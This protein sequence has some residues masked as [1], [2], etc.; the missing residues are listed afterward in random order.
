MPASASERIESRFKLYES[1]KSQNADHRQ[2]VA[3]VLR[4]HGIESIPVYGAIV[5]SN[6]RALASL[7]VCQL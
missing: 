3:A 2:V 4:W 6:P 5:L 7:T 1:P